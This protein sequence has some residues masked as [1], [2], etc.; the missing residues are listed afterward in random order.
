MCTII[1]F[2]LPGDADLERVS[3]FF[4]DPLETVDNRYVLAQLDTKE[5]YAAGTG[6]GCD[7]GTAIGSLAGSDRSGEHDLSTE[8]RKLRNKGWGEAK[9]EKWLE[10]KRRVK[11]KRARTARAVANSPQ[12]EADRWLTSIR[13]AVESGATRYLG[14]MYH[15]HRGR[16]DR[17]K[18]E[19]TKRQQVNLRATEPKDLLSFEE[20]VLHVFR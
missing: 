8:L 13:G 11:E 20:D 2:V 10:N 9:I 7:C 5:V 4:L 17:E 19:I 12:P 3:E 16:V 15:W 18:I 14:L 1:T 6:K